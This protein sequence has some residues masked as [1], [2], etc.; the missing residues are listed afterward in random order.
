M[1]NLY[2]DY[3]YD[4][5]NQYDNFNLLLDCFQVPLYF[6]LRKKINGINKPYELFLQDT[7]FE[8]SHKL[9]VTRIDLQLSNELTYSNLFD[10][11]Y[12]QGKGMETLREIKSLLDRDEIVMFESFHSRMPIYK[13][14]ASKD[15][16]YKEEDDHSKKGH[17]FVALAIKDDIL[18]YLE[19]KE[20]QN[21][22]YFKPFNDSTTI[23]MIPISELKT[24][25]D[26]Y[27]NYYEVNIKNAYLSNEMKEINFINTIKEITENFYKASCIRDGIKYYYNNQALSTLIQFLED[28]VIRLGDTHDYYTLDYCNMLAWKIDSIRKKRVILLECMKKMPQFSDQKSIDIIQRNSNQWQ[29]IVS[30]MS[31]KKQ[32]NKV[33]NHS[34]IV[35]YIGKLIESEEMVF[36]QL[37]ELLERISK[38][39]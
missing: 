35:K 19:A 11:K 8:L 13:Y 23:G 21:K 6:I 31:V 12:V 3:Y 14:Y 7:T 38:Q 39:A 9:D 29:F 2:L 33:Q 24:A 25:F 26:C 30:I 18:Y 28:G 5:N 37:K 32:T 1:K 36:Y 34:E 22:Q 15:F 4:K 27:L 20:M 10:I 17:V 16:L